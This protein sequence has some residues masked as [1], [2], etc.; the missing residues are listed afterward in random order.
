MHIVDDTGEDVHTEET[1]TQELFSV[2]AIGRRS[3]KL[4]QE[5]RTRREEQEERDLGAPPEIP[6]VEP[7][8]CLGEQIQLHRADQERE[9]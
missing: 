1:P 6:V 8:A 7:V 5:P 2:C 4:E 3:L 9:P